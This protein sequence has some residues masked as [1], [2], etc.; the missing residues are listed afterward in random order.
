[1]AVRLTTL[2]SAFFYTILPKI[3]F[4]CSF[5]RKDSPYS[6]LLEVSPSSLSSTFPLLSGTVSITCF[7]SRVHCQLLVSR[8]LAR[9]ICVCFVL[10]SVPSTQKLQ[11]VSAERIDSFQRNG[12]VLKSWDEESRLYHILYKR[13]HSVKC[14]V[15]L[16]PTY[17]IKAFIL[18]PGLM[19]NAGTAMLTI[20]RFLLSHIV[21]PGGCFFASLSE[22]STLENE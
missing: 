12:I 16:T 15:T 13:W 2:A 9:L 21:L 11:H 7:S 22:K 10:L 3:T 4:P 5:T 1:M 20:L 14:N 6:T 8:A 18:S 19:Y 17:F